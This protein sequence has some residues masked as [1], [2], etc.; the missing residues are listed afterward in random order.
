MTVVL[1]TKIKHFMGLANDTKPTSAD[2]YTGSTF[3]EYDTGETFVYDGADWQDDLRMIY[4]VSQG[5]NP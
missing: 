3:H 2:V 1:I 4:A 5:V